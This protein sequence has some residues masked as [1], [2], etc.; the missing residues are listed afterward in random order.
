[1]SLSRDQR[2]TT[3]VKQLLLNKV[4]TTSLTDYDTDELER[5]KFVIEVELRERDQRAKPSTSSEVSKDR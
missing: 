2:L 5:L 3:K 4:L 1:M